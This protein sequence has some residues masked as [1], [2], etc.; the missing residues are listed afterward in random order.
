MQH[1]MQ[2]GGNRFIFKVRV[3]KNEQSGSLPYFCF[4]VSPNTAL[5]GASTMLSER[6]NARHGAL[7]MTSRLV[8]MSADGRDTV[9]EHVLHM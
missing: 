9:R 4:Y 7:N 8:K 3:F 5:E 2:L 1:K 6:G